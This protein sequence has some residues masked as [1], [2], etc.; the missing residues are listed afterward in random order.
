MI[1]IERFS[2]TAGFVRKSVEN[3]AH[4]APPKN[5]KL[6][7]EGWEEHVNITLTYLFGM[8]EGKENTRN[9]SLEDVGK[10]FPGKEG[11]RTR[12]RINQ[13]IGKTVLALWQNSPE[14]LKS[15]YPFEELK[16]Q[17]GKPKFLPSTKGTARNILEDR[18]RGADYKFLSSKYSSSGLWYSRSLLEKYGIDVLDYKPNYSVLTKEI[19]QVG[20]ETKLDILMNIYSRMGS[21]RANYWEIYDRYFISLSELLRKLGFSFNPRDVGIFQD[22]LTKLNIPLGHL[23]K[24]VKSGEQEGRNKHYYFVF[25]FQEENIAQI[26]LPDPDLA[27]F[28]QKPVRQIAG[29]EVSEA[30]NTT[31]LYNP[32][33]YRSVLSLCRQLG[34]RVGGRSKIGLKVLIAGCLVPVFEHLN[35]ENSQHRTLYYPVTSEDMLKR[36][37]LQQAAHYGLI[38]P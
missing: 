35:R 11:F 36:S 15:E 32:G 17:L 26:L 16:K 12:Q 33:S 18:D 24:W 30:P 19:E 1:D 37:L 31:E 10:I 7:I 13:I 8:E 22:K 29:I 9:F 6:G 28:L 20:P 34:I 3:G 21:L 23:E 25:R 4:F 38:K 5:S 27:R 14:E 2:E